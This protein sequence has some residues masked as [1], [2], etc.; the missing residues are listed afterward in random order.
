M[1]NIVQEIYDF[2]L[3]LVETI[4]SLIYSITGKKDPFVP[5]TEDEPEVIIE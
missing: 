3:F 2:I 4:K 1:D 5:D